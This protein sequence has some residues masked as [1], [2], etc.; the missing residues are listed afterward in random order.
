MKKTFKNMMGSPFEVDFVK[1]D[2]SKY[3]VL[4]HVS[5]KTSRESIEKNGLLINQDTYKT[6]G[7]PTGM[8]FFSYPI[9]YNTSDCFRWSDEHYTLFVLNAEE[10]YKDGFIFYDDYFSSE[11]QSSQRNHLACDVS[12]PAKYIQKVIEF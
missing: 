9:D 2:I 3:D 8:L 7:E 1:H 4:F 10:L 12:I 5:L 11:D 6:L